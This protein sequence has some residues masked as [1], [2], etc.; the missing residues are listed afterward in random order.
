M[1]RGETDQKCGEEISRT[2]PARNEVEL[3][4]TGGNGFTLDFVGAASDARPTG[5]EFTVGAMLQSKT[6]LYTRA[7]I[8]RPVDNFLND[9][10]APQTT[11]RLVEHY[12]QQFHVGAID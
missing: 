8:T 6:N 2:R 1:D 10:V 12:F 7:C 4:T 11:L 3:E 5:D 9:F